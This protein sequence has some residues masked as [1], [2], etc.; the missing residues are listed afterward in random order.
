[1]KRG[2]VLGALVIVGAVSS[3]VAG[4][5]QAP[6]GGRQGQAAPAG[7]GAPEPPSARAL[8]VDKLGDNLFV[9][10]SA[11]PATFSGGNTAVFVRSNGVT[12]V[13]TK[14]PGWGRPLLEKIKELT[15]KPITTVINTHT[16]IG[17]LGGNPQ[18]NDIAMFDHAR[19]H[20]VAEYGVG[21]EQ[22]YAAEIPLG[23]DRR[24]R[25]LSGGGRGERA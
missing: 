6:A 20:R 19:A 2:M 12:V 21:R 17:H 7:R 5:Q 15:D 24:Q 25:R 23:A 4:I 13:D 16:H 9:I 10:R 1:M 14:V 3:V 8:A 22:P 18:L 11:N